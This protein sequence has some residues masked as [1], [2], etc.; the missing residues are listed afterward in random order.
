V[1]RVWTYTYDSYG[2]MLTAKLPRTDVNAT[3]TYAYYTCTTGSR[4]GEVET[5][6]D[7]L[8]HVWTFNTYNAHGQPLTITDP[9]GVV[10]TLTY[11]KRLRL[12]SRAVGTLKTSYSYYPTG[13]LD[14]V[15]LPDSSTVTYTYDPAHRLK[16][17]TDSLG[18]IIK[19]TL[20]NMGNHTGENSYDPSG[21]LHRTHAQMFNALNELSEDVNAAGTAGVTTTYSYDNDGN[22]TS[23][24]APLTRNTADQYDALNRLTQITDPNSGVTKLSYD[25]ND[26]LRSIL[27]PRSLST[28]YTPNGFGEVVQTVSPDTGTSSDTYD[29]D[30]NL[31]TATDARGALAT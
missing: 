28:I 22:Q 2:R 7:A 20:D 1:S 26:N 10:T 29:S 8:G 15:T 9:N 31:K 12:L 6:T 30:G 16:Q 13:L 19:Y 25:A 11:D 18:N 17:I 5:I 3:T 24:A 4:C 27:D 21:T 23:I 14:A